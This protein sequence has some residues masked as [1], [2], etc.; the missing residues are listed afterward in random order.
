MDQ[1]SLT[2]KQKYWLSHIHACERADIPMAD[3]ARQHQ[4]DKKRFYNWKWLLANRG[5]LAADVSSVTFTQV[6]LEKAS[7]SPDG[8]IL[9][10]PNGCRMLFGEL[11]TS[12]LQT[13]IQTLVQN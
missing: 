5:L 1:A 8:V 12:L 4:L 3:Y 10:F 2:E 13:V 7:H 9:Q 11:S 6:K